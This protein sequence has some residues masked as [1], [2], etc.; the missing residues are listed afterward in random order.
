MSKRITPVFLCVVLL[1]SLVCGCQIKS[2]KTTD[3]GWK[4]A[5]L[6][7]IEEH[8]EEYISYALVLID[9]DDIPELYL[10]GKNET[11]GDNVCAY[12]NEALIQ[13]PL[14][15]CGGGYYIEKTGQILNYNGTTGEFY[16]HIY[17]LLNDGFSLTFTACQR[18][19]LDQNEFELT[20]EFF[21]N[22]KPVDGIKHDAT[23]EENFDFS[24]STPL[25]KN[26]VDYNTIKKQI[27]N[28]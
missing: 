9:G 26:A 18:E 8:R 10:N 22:D 3:N 16:T 19:Y 15:R 12:K 28:Y 24:K 20:H 21:V 25:N 11:I 2:E 27:N 6:D 4:T 1:I 23:I 17:M 7:F 13:R 5:Y 14:L